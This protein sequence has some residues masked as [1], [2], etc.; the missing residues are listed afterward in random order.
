M[1]SPDQKTDAVI[2]AQAEEVMRVVAREVT[3][4]AANKAR[5]NLAAAWEW[6]RKLYALPRDNP[7]RDA[8]K[9]PA[10]AKLKYESPEED[11]WRVYEALENEGDR[12]LLPFLLH[13]GARI[14]ET[15]R[16]VWSDVD[17]ERQQVRLGTRKTA[18]G[19]M[20]YAWVP[21]TADL[22]AALARHREGSPG[23]IVFVSKRDGRPLV[24]RNKFMRRAC[25]AAGVRPFGFHAIRHLTATI[26]ARSGLDLPSVQAVLRHHNPV[27]T[28]RYIVSVN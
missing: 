10:D 20:E 9:L 8:A 2:V 15:F 19:G 13:M 6:G 27:T 21:M 23:L 14:Q 24:H 1:I 12:T 11:F 4:Y 17:F 5:K 7:F 28:A 26:L 22:A 25:V 3:A 18:T 16:L